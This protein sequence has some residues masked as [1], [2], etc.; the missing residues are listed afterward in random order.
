MLRRKLKGGALYI[1]LIISILIG[2]ILSVFILLSNFNNRETITRL[3]QTQLYWNL[4][5]AINLAQSKSF[6]PAESHHWKKNEFNDD[7]IK[8]KKL[9]WGAFVLIAAETKNRHQYLQRTGLFGINSFKDTAIMVNDFGRPVNLAGTINFN[10]YCF[11]PKGTYKT[12]FI[13]GQGFSSTG[14]ISGNIKSAPAY[15]P[16]P[17]KQFIEAL[18]NCS[19]EIS[20]TTDSI[21]TNIDVVK[22]KFTAKTAIFQASNLHLESNNLKGNIKLIINNEVIIDKDAHLEDVLIIAKKVRIRKEFK[23]SLQVIASDSIIVEENSVLNYPSSL[24]VHIKENTLHDGMGTISINNNCRIEGAIL[25]LGSKKAETP[26]N[27]IALD[28]ECEI[29]GLIY[30]SGYAG[31][32]GK[33]AGNIF[34]QKLLLKTPSSVYENHLLNCDIDSK[35]HSNTAVI[36]PL[37]ENSKLNRCVKWL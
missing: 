33:I 9:Q 30:S 36:P 26:N 25:C 6:V 22:N 31:I 34:A 27:I 20:S 37:F 5:S 19:K 24:I 12:T 2:T 1:A 3:S 10:G 17:G 29:Y 4:E 23:G 35:K 32:Q 13:E 16:E 21:I 14:D 7:S 28:K 18:E 11:L 15:I 8:I